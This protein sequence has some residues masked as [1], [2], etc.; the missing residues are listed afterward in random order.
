MGK[1]ILNSKG[2]AIVLNAMEERIANHNQQLVNSLGYEIDMTSLTQIVKKVSEQKFFK[3]APADY[4]PVKVG[5]GAWSSNLITYRSY[6]LGD[7]F[8]NGVINT[9]SNSGRLAMVDSGVDSI[10]I[11]VVNWAKQLEY[12]IFD[13]QL[14]SR[15]GNWDLV[16][17]K[18]KSRKINW[19]LGIQ[20]VAFLGL[21]GSAS[22]LGL[23]NQSNVTINTTLLT[24]AN[25]LAIKSMTGIQLK[26]FCGA[27]L[28]AYRVNCA[29]TAWPTHFLIPESDYNGLASFT[30]ADFPLRSVLSVLEETLKTIT[31]NPGFKILPLAYAD[32]AFS[33]GVLST[34]RYVLLNYEE[35]SIRMDIPVDYTSTLA[36]SLNNFS[37]QNVGY[38]QFT[39]AKAYRELEMLYIDVTP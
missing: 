15:S 23:L 27:L 26:A 5:E 16:S 19:D 30:S 6:A 10:T 7:D 32:P 13:L 22:V 29:R 11:P 24:T 3:I 14:A 1:K 21:S 33:S 35:E 12:T 31:M 39:G 4:L 36:N 8:S 2:E 9:G 20:K 28:E 25:G 34:Q 18:E 38:G 37:L 17:S